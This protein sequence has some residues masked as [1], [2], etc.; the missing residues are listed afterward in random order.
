MNAYEA[1]RRDIRFAF[2]EVLNG[3][4][5]YQSLRRGSDATPDIIDAILEEG[6]KFAENV[7]APLNSVGD[8]QGCRWNDCQV[9]TPKGFKEAYHQYIEGGWMGLAEDPE[10]GG[11]GLPSSL[12]SIIN[13]MI[14]TANHAWTMYPTLS[15]GAISTIKTHGSEWHQR[16]FLP[17]LATGTWS[18]TMCLTEA[19]SGSDLGLLR[20]RAEPQP[21]GSYR[22]TGSKIFIS[23]G[24]HDLTENIVHVVLARLPDAPA[25]VK[26]ISLFLVPKYEIHEDGSIG[27][28]NAVHCGSIEHKMG[29][30]G[31][32]TCTMNFDGAK[33]YLIGPPNKGMSCMFT[34]I[35]ESRLGVAQQGHAH[36]E[37]SFQGSVAYAR[38]RLQMR[39]PKRA[40]PDQPADPIIAHPDVRRML[41]T[42][43]AFAEGGRVLNYYCAQQVDLTHEADD[44]RRQLA[45]ARLALL[46]PIAKGFLTEVGMEATNLGIQVYGGHGFITESGM[47]QRVRDERITVIYEGTTGIQALDLL[48]RKILASRGELLCSFTQEIEAFCAAATDLDEF[49]TPLLRLVKEWEALSQEVGD[50]CQ[51]DPNELGASAYD[52][53]MF[54]GYTTLAYF[55]ARSVQVAQ[56]QLSAGNG[57]QAFYQA[58]IHTARFYFERLLPRTGPLVAA[59]KSGADNLMTLNGGDFIF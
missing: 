50:R 38:E 13:E 45:E 48:G 27:E 20:T 25:G 17:P 33:G 3:K 1:P 47:E 32:A 24:E 10:L 35:N 59:I 57:E 14:A 44:E 26:G 31:N 21:D 29:I 49:T 23:A 58:K 28:R 36:T 55:W 30:H 2:Q 37:A 12:G 11:Q 43:K 15:H 40:L 7:L 51:D 9:T 8:R 4:E 56:R 22:I 46:T 16:V 19:H 18:G 5:H 6:A 41:L 54:S 52:F 53:L 39:A 42:Q 34:F